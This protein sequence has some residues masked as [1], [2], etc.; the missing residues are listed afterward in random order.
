MGISAIFIFS[1]T[2]PLIDEQTI[3]DDL[4][5]IIS[6]KTKQY[7][8]CWSTKANNCGLKKGFLYV[9]FSKRKDR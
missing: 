2:L 6:N 7:N 5:L 8:I 1:V 4:Q 3:F 9:F